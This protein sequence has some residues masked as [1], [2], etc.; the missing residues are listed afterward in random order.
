MTPVDINQQLTALEPKIRTALGHDVQLQ[1]Q[2]SSE[3][4]WVKTDPHPLEQA[5]LH[6]VTHVKGHMPTGGT[7]TLKA[8]RVELTRKDLTH[9]DMAPGPYIQLT[10]QDTG[11]GID[12]AS[13]PHVFEP[14][15]PVHEG[16]KGDLTLATAYGIMRQSGGSIDVESEKGKGSEWTILLPETKERPQHAAA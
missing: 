7:L 16:Q 15:H 12:D 6:L 9:A 14:Y 1:W 2:H 10:L 4:L 11:A 3:E 8:S 13:L 5:F